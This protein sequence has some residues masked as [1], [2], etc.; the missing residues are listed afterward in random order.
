MCKN[1]QRPLYCGEPV[2]YSAVL[3][4]FPFSVLAAR[5]F[6][7]RKRILAFPERFATI[8]IEADYISSMRGNLRAFQFEFPSTRQANNHPWKETWNERRE[9]LQRQCRR[10]QKAAKRK[11][12]ATKGSDPRLAYSPS[13]KET[14]TTQSRKRSR[15]RPQTQGESRTWTVLEEA[16]GPTNPDWMLVCPDSSRKL[17][18]SLS[19]V[20]G[21]P[22]GSAGVARFESK[23]QSGMADFILT[24]P[25]HFCNAS[26]T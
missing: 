13:V 11:G 20:S 19:A 22:R 21:Y 24:N 15:K 23:E 25:G 10:H 8:G 16:R 3:P 12:A 7:T 18:R 4:H 17:S 26:G 2:G 1:V 9:R 6:S 14:G 5:K